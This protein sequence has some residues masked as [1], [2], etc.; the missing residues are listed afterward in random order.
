MN[1]LLHLDPLD[2]DPDMIENRIDAYC[3]MAEEFILLGINP[4]LYTSTTNLPKID[5]KMRNFEIISQSWQ[6][7]MGDEYKSLAY[8]NNLPSD[9]IREGIENYNKISVQP[10][11]I[12]TNTPSAL[13]RKVWKKE[14]IL[15]YELGFFN[16][17]PFPKFYQFDPIGFY[18][19]SL[20]AKYPH[21]GEDG[22]NSEINKL[23]CKKHSIME[24]LGINN[25]DIGSVHATYIPLYSDSWASKL[26]Y[27]YNEKIDL[28]LNYASNNKNKLIITNE[29]PQ[30]PLS[31]IE[32]EKINS[33]K[34]ISLIE[35]ED[36]YG[37]GSK[38]ALMCKHTHT[39]S[40]SIG[41]QSLFWGNELTT[42]IQSSM[43]NWAKLKDPIK[44][45]SSYLT[46]FHIETYSNLIEKLPMLEN[47]N[48]YNNHD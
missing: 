37:L 14:L 28:L 41:L 17:P 48:P 32:K 9:V 31:T 8:S 5:S 13:I 7:A 23:E 18:H 24:A 39:F 42:P 3:Q 6:S 29:R 20:L 11:I 36:Q 16:R 12:I 47:F 25:S 43:S 40:P 30:S 10:D 27:F 33:F 45:L 46:N 26:E 44:K 15:H 34:N 2:N 19:T 1:I 21:I 38:L 35:N 4:I 22:T